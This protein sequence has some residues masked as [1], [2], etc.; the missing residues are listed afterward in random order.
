MARDLLDAR[1]L[2]LYR[3]VETILREK[4]ADGE[5]R[6]GD[7]VPA[8]AALSVEFGVS[9]DTVRQ[10][11]EALERDDLIDRQVGRGTFVR[12]RAVAAG[13][14]PGRR[15]QLWHEAIALADDAR[16]IVSQSAVPAPPHV[17]RLLAVELS[18]AVPFV[19]RMSAEDPKWG[20]KRYVH[21]RFAE[22]MPDICAARAFRE[23][24]GEYAGCEVAA[25]RLWVEAIQAEPRFARLFGLPPGSPL[26]SIWWTD[27]AEGAVVAC[28]QM[29]QPGTGFAIGFSL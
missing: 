21:P 28:T 7:R 25:D 22:V 23:A 1:D 14:S 17:A 6:P 29:L 15:Q 9:R 20:V 26:L 8:E 2:S 11:L 10:A 5:L 13:E 16:G 12:A 3:Q 24:L 27:R 4:I 18:T 19:I